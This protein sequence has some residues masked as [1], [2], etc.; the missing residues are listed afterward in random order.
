MMSEPTAISTRINEQEQNSAD[1]PPHEIILGAS[2]PQRSAV[3]TEMTGTG[4]QSTPGVARARYDTR[5]LLPSFVLG[6]IGTF[7]GIS[8]L[9]WLNARLPASLAPLATSLFAAA[10]ASVWA[11][12]L[13]R[14]AYR[15]WFWRVEVN[16]QEVVYRRGFLWPKCSV[17][18]SELARVEVRQNWLQRWLG[19]GHVA[20][21]PE[22]PGVEALI[23]VGIAEPHF[24]AEQITQRLRRVRHHQVREQRLTTANGTLQTI[25][26]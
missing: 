9:V 15:G 10:V 8:G 2:P 21:L 14:W 16:D 12:L 20:L 4:V 6:V 11:F 25:L 23:I 13:F 19:F 24:L 5:H 26:G 3:D 1:H 18:L 7:A 17:S 22:Q